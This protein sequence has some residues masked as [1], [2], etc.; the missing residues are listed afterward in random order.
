[1]HRLFAALTAVAPPSSET[2]TDGVVLEIRE[3]GAGDSLEAVRRTTGS[4]LRQ[5]AA[6]EGRILDPATVRDPDWWFT[7]GG[8]PFFVSAF[9]ACYPEDSSRYAFGCEEV[10]LLFLAAEAFARRRRRGEAELPAEHKAAIRSAFSA[11]GRPYDLALTLSVYEADRIVK[12]I[13]FGAGPVP[14][15]EE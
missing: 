4:T 2:P 12:P 6:T 11:A 3:A 8:T 10:Y 9:A 5:L 7:A 1:M 13:S 14:W 15:W